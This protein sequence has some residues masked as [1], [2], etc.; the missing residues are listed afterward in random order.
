MVKKKDIKLVDTLLHRD[1]GK[2]HMAQLQVTLHTTF[3]HDWY[4]YFLHKKCMVYDNS[5]QRE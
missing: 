2:W 4:E 3:T 5:D 1:P